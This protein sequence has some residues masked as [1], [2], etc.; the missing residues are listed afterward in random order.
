MKKKH[1]VLAEAW[2]NR[3]GP[4]VFTTASHEG[5][6][7][8]IFVSCIEIDDAGN[9]II[10]DNYFHKTNQNIADGSKGVVLFIT[11]E[12]KSFQIKG[13]ITCYETGPFYDFM[14]SKNPTK[15]PG[16]RAVVIHVSEVYSG[17]T[18]LA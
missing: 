15:H 1:E 14:K 8:S 17:A 4:A 11:E 12:D 9:I 3:K 6:A 10:A 5:I 13:E 7:N 2:K 16:H 18:K